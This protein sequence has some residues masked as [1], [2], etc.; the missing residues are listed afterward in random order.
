MNA[1][2]NYASEQLPPGLGQR[3]VAEP[4]PTAMG[5]PS[6]QPLELS[7]GQNAAWESAGRRGTAQPEQGEAVPVGHRSGFKLL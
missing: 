5:L 2:N 4:W 1:I 6:T 3:R 7:A